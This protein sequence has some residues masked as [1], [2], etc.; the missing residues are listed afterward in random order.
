MWR[1]VQNEHGM[2]AWYKP[3]LLR[4]AHGALNRPRAVPDRDLVGAGVVRAAVGVVAG[5]AVA[6]E[7]ERAAAG[8]LVRP[9]VV[10]RGVGGAGVGVRAG[11]R[12]DLGAGA[13]RPRPARSATAF[14][15]RG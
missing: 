1:G 11:A 14:E 13:C 4:E 10:A 3:D 12:H 2:N 6:A 15:G 7:A 5:A 8:V 9:D